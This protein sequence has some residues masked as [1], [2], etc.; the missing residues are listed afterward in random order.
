MM[1]LSLVRY[2]LK[3]ALRDK[4]YLSALIGMIVGVSLSFFSASAALTEQDQFSLVF[5][6]GGLRL[7][8]LA[9][10]V[11]F[12]VFFV[13][14]SFDARD[15]EY[16]LT[17]PVSRFAFVFSHNIAFTVLACGIAAALSLG[18]VTFASDMGQIAGSLLWAT[19]IT[20]EYIIMANL[21]FFFAMVLSS[22]VSAGLAT[23]GFYV[24]GRL[25]GQI[26]GVIYFPTGD[27]PG[28][29]IL[30][31]VM[32]IISMITPRFDLMAQTSWL[33]YGTTQIMRDYALVICGGGVFLALII[34]ATVIDLVRREF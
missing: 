11:L 1:S 7:L 25:M 29:Q 18:V 26:L 6:A 12:V 10:L 15:V 33:L 32:K 19:G 9:G 14:R 21:A 34:T 22:P 16:L 2:V 5:M 23:A 27:L 3:G 30:A 17:R 24:L 28:F 8:G 4:V 31:S 13:R 20:F